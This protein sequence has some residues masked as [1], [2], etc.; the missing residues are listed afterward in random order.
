MRPCICGIQPSHLPHLLPNQSSLAPTFPSTLACA[1]SATRVRASQDKRGITTTNDDER[2]RHRATAS[3]VDVNDGGGV[4]VSETSVRVSQQ[5]TNSQ[6]HFGERRTKQQTTNDNANDE[7]R[8]TNECIF[9]RT[10][11]KSASQQRYKG[12]A[13]DLEG[14]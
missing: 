11:T 7:R 10:A 12:L 14:M 8:T 6:T 4:A 9:S 13:N 3:T 2:R 5:S 1:S